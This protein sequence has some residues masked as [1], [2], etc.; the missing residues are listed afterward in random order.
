L[1]ERLLAARIGDLPITVES[2]GTQALVGRGIDGH[3][4]RALSALGGDA[5]GHVAQRFTQ[6]MVTRADLILTAESLH[7]SVIVQSEPLTF[8]RAFTILEFALLGRDLPRLE[9]VNREALKARVKE[10]A[11]RRG[12]VDAPGE[13]A[14]EIPD[15][16]GAGEAAAQ[17]VAATLDMAINEVSAAL[18]LFRVTVS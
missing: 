18:G 2:A 15:P 17:Q 11:G 9:D 6:Q 1:A 14:D 4:A 3:S 10:I 13:G 8:R 12:W 7:R 16:F 5:D